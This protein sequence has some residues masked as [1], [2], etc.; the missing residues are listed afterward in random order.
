METPES[1]PQ[2]RDM[3]QLSDP[4]ETG[5]QGFDSNREGLERKLGRLERDQQFFTQLGRLARG[6]GLEGEERMEARTIPQRIAESFV[7]KI[8]T[9]RAIKQIYADRAANIYG[10][11]GGMSSGEKAV[12]MV[13]SQYSYLTGASSFEK[14]R[15]RWHE[16]S[17]AQ[18]TG[19]EELRKTAKKL[20]GADKTA[21][22][23]ASF[24]ISGR[25][26]QKRIESLRRKLD[27]L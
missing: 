25:I 8:A 11:G 22:I 27:S 20:E 16:I 13:A 24:K 18:N 5:Q 7:G 1:S 4:Q 12:R 14:S 21:K 17:S 10:N 9:R 3:D 26:R 2:T 19:H 23:V 6:R 15:D